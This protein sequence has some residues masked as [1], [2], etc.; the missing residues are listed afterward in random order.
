V[1][2]L[3]LLSCTSLGLAWSIVL[4]AV[5]TVVIGFL[6]ARHAKAIYLAI[7]HF[8]DPHVKPDG[9]RDRTARPKKKH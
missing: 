3:V 4:T 8:C 1:L 5:P 6:F 7:D 2:G 9:I